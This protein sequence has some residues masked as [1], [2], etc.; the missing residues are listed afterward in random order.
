MI[1]KRYQDVLFK[2]RDKQLIRDG[3]KINRE[4]AFSDI[5]HFDSLVVKNLNLFG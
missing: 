3:L 5:Y 2:I 4:E 1:H